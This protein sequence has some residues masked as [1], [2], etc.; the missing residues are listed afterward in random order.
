MLLVG[1]VVVTVKGVVVAVI[2]VE[3]VV[4]VGRLCH[5][6]AWNQMINDAVYIAKQ[7]RNKNSVSWYGINRNYE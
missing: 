5:M 7:R 4:A 1:A 2:V 3:G 6:V